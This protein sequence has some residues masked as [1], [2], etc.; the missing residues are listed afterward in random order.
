MM[1]V[2]A[3]AAVSVFFLFFSFIGICD[4]DL[5]GTTVLIGQGMGAQNLEKVR[6]VIGSAYL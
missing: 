6:S 1:G 2:D 3:I 4:R 5:A